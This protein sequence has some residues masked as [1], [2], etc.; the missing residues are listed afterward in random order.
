MFSVTFH[1]APQL[2]LKDGKLVIHCSLRLAG[3]L[4][5]DCCQ[6]R[7][8]VLT[9]RLNTLVATTPVVPTS[10]LIPKKLCSDRLCALT[11]RISGRQ[12]AQPFD[13]PS[14]C[15]CYVALPSR[16]FALVVY[17]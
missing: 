1:L 7:N 12:K 4:F 15:A 16:E 14:A 9:M 5:N 3:W 2:K 11:L 10:R 8:L 17:D 6:P 13:G